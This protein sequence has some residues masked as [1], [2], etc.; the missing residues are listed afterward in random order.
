[1]WFQVDEDGDVFPARVY[2]DNETGYRARGP[3]IFP[4][5][6]GRMHDTPPLH[7]WLGTAVQ[8][9]LLIAPLQCC[10]F[11]AG[12]CIARTLGDVK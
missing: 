12:T 2:Y 9:R 7:P 6:C 4:L 5:A 11:L 1:M 8:C 3:G 10:V